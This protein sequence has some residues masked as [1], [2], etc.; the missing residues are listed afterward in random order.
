MNRLPKNAM[1]QLVAITS[2]ASPKT[3]PIRVKNAAELPTTQLAKTPLLSQAPRGETL[4]ALMSDKYSKTHV[5]KAGLNP[6]ASAVHPSIA[7]QVAGLKV[8][9]PSELSKARPHAPSSQTTIL[10]KGILKK[11][12][13]FEVSFNPNGKVKKIR[14]GSEISFEV[15]APLVTPDEQQLNKLLTDYKEELLQVNDIIFNTN[16]LNNKANQELTGLLEE[17]EIGICALSSLYKKEL[18]NTALRKEWLYLLENADS[19]KKKLKFDDEYFSL[20]NQIKNTASLLKKVNSLERI[21][22]SNEI[23]QKFELCVFDFNNLLK[24]EFFELNKTQKNK[25]RRKGYKLESLTKNVLKKYTER[26]EQAKVEVK[27][28][29]PT[30]SDKILQKKLLEREIENLAENVK[31]L[32]ALLELLQ[33]RIGEIEKDSHNE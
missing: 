15:Q 28:I 27:R 21:D 32:R 23:Y 6:R 24:D 26:F 33:Q 31:D 14:W 9:S 25:I 12:S 20:S 8:K 1:A 29:V 7:S 30:G 5:N 4:A 18:K 3:P 13:S 16:K 2:K 19:M 17:I 22:K 10:P 11:S